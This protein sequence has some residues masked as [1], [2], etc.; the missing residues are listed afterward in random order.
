MGPRAETLPVSHQA[1]LILV[2]AAVAAAEN[3]TERACASSLLMFF[4]DSFVSEH[5]RQCFNSKQTRRALADN[6]CSRI[7][8]KSRRY[9]SAHLRHASKR[10]MF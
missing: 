5:L 1:D 8:D 9:R 3:V 6:D 7:A 2:P 4:A 10:P